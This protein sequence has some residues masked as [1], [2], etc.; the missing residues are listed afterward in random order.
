MSEIN[1]E[2]S[3]TEELEKFNDIKSLLKEIN[4][5][6]GIERERERERERDCVFCNRNLDNSKRICS[7]CIDE[8]R[9]KLS[10]GWYIF[11][12]ILLIVPGFAYKNYIENRQ[13]EWDIKNL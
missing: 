2:N 1:K 8:R 6:K 7:V 12:L 4:F 11:L 13:Q 9:P 3:K 10:K 5:Q